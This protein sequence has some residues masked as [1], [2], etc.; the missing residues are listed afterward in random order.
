[1]SEPTREELVRRLGVANGDLTAARQSEER[2]KESSV[3]YQHAWRDEIVKRQAAERRL[4]DFQEKLEGLMHVK[5]HVTKDHLR[6]LLGLP[7]LA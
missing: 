5:K 6:E 3:A 1:M 4:R 7:P 2:A